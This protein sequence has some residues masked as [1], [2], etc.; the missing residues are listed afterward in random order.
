MSGGGYALPNGEI[1]G[2]HMLKIRCV[3][4]DE[5]LVARLATH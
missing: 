2:T 4:T 3:F 5:T 1:I